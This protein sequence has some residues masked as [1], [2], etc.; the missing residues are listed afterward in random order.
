MKEGDK[1]KLIK[2]NVSVLKKRQKAKAKGDTF[3][4][5]PTGIC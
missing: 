5:K 2:W 3:L 1:K 4:S